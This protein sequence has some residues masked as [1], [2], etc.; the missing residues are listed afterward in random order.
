[1]KKIPILLLYGIT[2][3][4]LLQSCSKQLIEQ[5]IRVPTAN[6]Y[7]KTAEGFKN[8][9]NACYTQTRSQLNGDAVAMSLYG[10]D[11][12]TH[13]SDIG[14]DEFN[15]YL[16]TLNPTDNILYNFWSGYYL[17][18][19]ACNTAI[20]RAKDVT[21]MDQNALNSKVGEAYFLRAWY[22]SKLVVQ[23]GALP[24]ITEEVTSIQTTATRSPVDSVYDLIISDLKKADEFLPVTQSDFGRATKPAA[25]ALL[26]RE[27]LFLD[28]YEEA[29]SYAEKVINNYNFKLL[30]DFAKLWDPNN[31]QNSEIIWS[32]QFSQDARLSQPAS[33]LHLYFTPRYDLHPGMTRALNYDR[34]YPRYMAT[35]FYLDLMQSNRWKDSRYDKSWREIYLANYAPTLPP[36]MKLGDTAYMVVPYAVSQNV[37]N[38]KPY[39]IFD[40][41][42]YYHGDTS[43]GALQIY[44]CLIK[45]VDPNRASINAADGTRDIIEIR[46]AEMYFIAAESLMNQAKAAEGTEYL[47]VV[48]RRAAW[49]G[50]EADME[51]S[52]SELTLDLILNERAL[53]FGGE[54]MRWETLKRTG[55]LLERAKK[56]NPEAAVNISEKFLLR[57]IPQ[58]FIDRL[59]NKNDFKQNPGY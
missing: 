41:N 56:Y 57:P 20:S 24:L 50:H 33:S 44:P 43:Y 2:M 52:P 30:P 49:P 48:L 38:S 37:K 12:W 10:A 3:T 26:A 21:G 29:G 32:I 34:P 7:Y 40:I 35:R 18:I 51:I 31:E 25:E 53:E 1:M 11:L 23:F 27:Y 16:P 42:S 59:T 45:Y 39:P 14:A 9:V 17:G 46:L 47:N 4:F 5:D 54:R 36:G 8:L 19:A 28:N 15:S 58:E 22:Y 55:T 13:A 6:S